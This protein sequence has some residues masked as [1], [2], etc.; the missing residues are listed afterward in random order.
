[1]KKTH[2]IT[3]I[4]LAA[5]FA[6]IVGMVGNY[7]SYESFSTAANH[8]DREYHV[9]GKYVPEKGV[10]FNP[11]ENANVFTFYMVDKDGQESKVVCNGDVPQHFELTEQIVV[12]GKM[13]EDGFYATD[14]LTKCPSK[15]KNQ[16]LTGSGS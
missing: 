14:L 3:L 7:S 13:T 5:A 16:D 2:I 12:I 1:M 15:Y 8:P 10:E 9:V 6:L 4:L 11:E